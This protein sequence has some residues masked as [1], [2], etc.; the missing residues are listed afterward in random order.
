MLKIIFPSS[1]LREKINHVHS[2]VQPRYEFSEKRK[3]VNLSSKLC[4]F[5]LSMH[6]QRR[7]FSEREFPVVWRSPV[8]RPSRERTPGRTEFA[9]FFSFDERFYLG[10]RHAEENVRIRR[11]LNECFP[12][13]GDHRIFVASL[14]RWI[15][16]KFRTIEFERRERRRKL[17]QKDHR[18]VRNVL[19]IDADASATDGEHRN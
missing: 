17:D 13:P 7:K 18:L 1:T 19:E 9:Q 8:S 5:V 3:K 10:H 11:I 14:R 6:Q 12:R 2:L 15:G 16:L 4:V